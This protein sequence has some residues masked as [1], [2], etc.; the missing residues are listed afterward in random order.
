MNNREKRMALGVAALVGLLMLYYVYS[1]IADQFTQRETKITQLEQTVA[2]NKQTILAGNVAKK[3]LTE[4]EH[5]SLPSNKEIAPTKYLNWLLELVDHSKLESPDVHDKGTFTSAASKNTPY[6]KFAFQVKGRTS[7]DMTQLVHFLYEFYASNQL[8]TIRS[9][10]LTPDN[11]AKKLDVV[12]EI[13]SLVLPTA[14]RTDE[15]AE[16]PLKQLARGDT[17]AYQKLIGGRNLFAE[18]TPPRVVPPGPAPPTPM[19]YAKYTNVTAIMEDDSGP[20][21]WVLVKPTDKL[22]KLKEGEDFTVDGVTYNVVK[23]KSRRVV[24]KSDG[25]Q[26]QVSLGESLHDA[27]PVPAEEL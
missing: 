5:R 20:Q 25:K 7:I 27:A 3:R 10:S 4:W 6:D 12:L 16:K 14:D 24:L 22:F 19:D 2:K 13:E 21:L 15:L 8:H 11:N 9:I 26:V 23:I 17:A 1:S 18:Y